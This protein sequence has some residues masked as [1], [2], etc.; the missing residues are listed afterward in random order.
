MTEAQ[1]LRCFY[2]YNMAPI[3][4]EINNIHIK[5]IIMAN[6]NVAIAQF[7]RDVFSGELLTA[8]TIKQINPTNGIA[9]RIKVIIQSPTDISDELDN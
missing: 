9:V 2:I 4:Q 7:L 6:T 1:I 3:P 8:Q 5:N